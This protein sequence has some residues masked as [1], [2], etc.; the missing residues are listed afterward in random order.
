MINIVFDRWHISEEDQ[1]IF[2]LEIM[3]SDLS[4]LSYVLIA[5]MYGNEMEM[6]V[7]RSIDCILN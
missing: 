7:L 2:L 6:G 5:E 4:Q 1:I 3:K